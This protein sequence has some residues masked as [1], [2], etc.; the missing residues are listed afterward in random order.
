MTQAVKAD[1]TI[2]ADG[3]FSKF[4]KN[5]NH[6]SVSISSHFAGLVMQDCPQYKRGHAE[7]FL[8][9]MGP[10]LVYQ[11]S[12][13]ETRMLIDIQG[14]VPSN[15]SQ[16]VQDKVGPE[17]RGKYVLHSCIILPNYYAMS[18]EFTPAI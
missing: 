2:V 12:S 4:R 3:C 17:L 6:S 5:F 8:T 14:K 9:S 7:I 16:Y 1:L 15:L 11:I 13:S 18:S 10:V